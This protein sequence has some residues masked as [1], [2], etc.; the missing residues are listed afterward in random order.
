METSDVEVVKF[1]RKIGNRPQD[2]KCES[3][4]ILLSVPSSYQNAQ[5]LESLISGNLWGSYCA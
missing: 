2:V 1:I 4:M 5:R 3:K